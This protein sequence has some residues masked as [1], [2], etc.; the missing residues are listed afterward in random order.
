MST[1]LNITR[2]TSRVIKAPGG[3]STF[4]IGG[5]EPAKVAAVETTAVEVVVDETPIAAPKEVKPVQGR[6]GIIVAGNVESDFLAEGISK[7]LYL[8][9]VSGPVLSKVND[10]AALPYAAQ[11]LAR[12]VDVVIASAFIANDPG[13]AITNAL[14]AS[15]LQLGLSG[16]TP[17]IPALP[18][19]DT[20]LEARALLPAAAEG[21]A[22]AAVTVLNL[23]FGGSLEVTAAPEPVIPPKTVFTPEVDSVETLLDHLRESLKQHGAR[24]IVGLGRKFRIA[25]DDK[26]GHIE[27]NEFTKVINEHKLGWTAAQ[28]KLVFQ[29]FDTDKSGGISYD[30][31]IIRIRGQ[32]NERRKNLVLLAFEIL[33]ADKSGIVDL[34]DIRA[35]YD[36]SKHPD[37]ISGKRTTD[38]V[39]SEFLDTFDTE[40]KDGKV[41]PSE[42]CKYYSNVSASI[43]E[44]DYFELMIRNAWRISGGEG[45]CANS[46]CR[47]VLITHNDGRQTV[48]EIKN[49]IGIKDNDFDAFL[50]NLKKQ[51]INDVAVIELANGTK[52]EVASAKA[53]KPEKATPQVEQVRPATAPAPSTTQSRSFNPRRQPGGASSLVLG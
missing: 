21:W 53:T 41:T 24:G 31:F 40:E 32:L 38:S 39:L 16:R 46:S 9:G 30:E 1:D 36:A 35:K 50:A 10:I 27:L 18:A 12:S 29:S 51:N 3:G 52:Y 20:L 48:Q 26:S 33:D 6:V 15:L 19:H 25:D 4:K 44:D 22:N 5:D 37:V 47:R 34:D 17:I 14:S 42:F 45:W 28:I 7:A 49:D 13:R 43:D 2:P 11:N 8:A 23:Q